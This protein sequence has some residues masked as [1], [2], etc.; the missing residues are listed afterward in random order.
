[1]RTG[2]DQEGWRRGLKPSFPDLKALWRHLGVSGAFP[3][4]KADCSPDGR[5][6]SQGL[7][8]H[9]EKHVNRPARGV[10][11]H[12]RRRL[13][14]ESTEVPFPIP[15]AFILH[16]DVKI[17]RVECSATRRVARLCSPGMGVCFKV[18]VL[19]GG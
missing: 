2:G 11:F 6:Y 3:T 1:M 10:H 9:V 7:L 17:A 12:H 15:D 4:G 14:G 5:A 8:H 16:L 13:V 19:N 18:K